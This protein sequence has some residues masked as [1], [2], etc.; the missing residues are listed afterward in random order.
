MSAVIPQS[1]LDL[2]TGP[3]PAILATVAPNGQ[4]ENTVVWCSWDGEHV[5]VNTVVGR[6]KDRNMRHNPRVAL[7][8]VDPA[9]PYRWLDV[10]GYVEEIIPDEGFANINAHAKLYEGVDEYYG[11]YAPIERRGTEERVVAKIKPVRVLVYPH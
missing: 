3:I 2:I 4:P 10:R 8:A 6:R 5:L 1:H 9:D 11:G 7:T